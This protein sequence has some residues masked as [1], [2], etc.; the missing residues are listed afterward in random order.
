MQLTPDER[1]TVQELLLAQSLS[2][3]KKAENDPE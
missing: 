1:T 2:R 3:C